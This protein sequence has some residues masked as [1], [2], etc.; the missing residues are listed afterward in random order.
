M[1]IIEL[2]LLL[3]LIF[4]ISSCINSSTEVETKELLNT[5][6]KLEAF[7]IDG[8]IIT[9]P[10]EQNYNIKFQSDSTFIGKSACNNIGGNYELE[11]D[12]SIIVTKLGT[13]FANCGEDSFYGAFYSAVHKLSSYYLHNNRLT[14]FYGNNSKLIFK[15]E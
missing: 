13:T 15:A 7:E 2:T 4:I 11:G 14:L 3:F 6:W 10:V 12:N 1:K 8:E 9:P 5:L